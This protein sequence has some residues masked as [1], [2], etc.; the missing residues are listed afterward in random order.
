MIRTGD[1]GT[2]KSKENLLMSGCLDA[3]FYLELILID[4]PSLC[5]DPL[6]R[7]IL[8]TFASSVFKK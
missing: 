2:A 4:R 1:H 5:V 6:S 3:T 8:R 7:I